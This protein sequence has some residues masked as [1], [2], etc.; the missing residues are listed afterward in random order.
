MNVN[1]IVVGDFHTNAYIAWTD[2]DDSCLLIDA[3]APADPIIDALRHAT[4]SPKMLLLTHGHIDHIA[5]SDD[6]RSA[7]P[8][9]Q[10]CSSA[11]TAKMLRR[12][13]LNLSVLLGGPRTFQAPHVIVQDGQEI[14][15]GGTRLRAISLDGH[16]PGSFCFFSR[17][18]PPIIFTGDTLSR[19]SIGRTDFPG[20]SLQTLLDGIRTNIMT[21]PDDTVVYAGHGPC[22][23]VAAERANPFLQSDATNQ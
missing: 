6:L 5:G 19:G 14:G 1:T 12:P 16:A 7:F 3:P 4:L 15:A 20:G 11:Q 18:Q 8:E 10:V 13:S 2:P 17:T 22:T 23:T 21:L 9:M